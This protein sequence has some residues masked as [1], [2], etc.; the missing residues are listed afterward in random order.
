MKNMEGGEKVV[1]SKRATRLALVLLVCILLFGSCGIDDPAVTISGVV[2]DSTS[3]LPIDSAIIQ[4]G[5]T[6]SSH[7]FYTDTLGRYNLFAGLGYRT[8]QVFCRKTGYQTK[9]R[10]VRSSKDNVTITGV[11]FQL[12]AQQDST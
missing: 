9:S 3:G 8:F 2:T 7:P 6:I 5:D 12:V 4:D 11:D 1:V 10:A